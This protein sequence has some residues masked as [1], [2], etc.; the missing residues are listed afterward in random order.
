MKTYQT[1][2]NIAEIEKEIATRT[3]ER[4]QFLSKTKEKDLKLATNPKLINS[5]IEELC[6]QVAVY[7]PKATS[8]IYL[9]RRVSSFFSNRSR[10][11][12]VYRLKF[13]GNVI[14]EE[15][16]ANG[17]E[18]KFYVD[19]FSESPFLELDRVSLMVTVELPDQTTIIRASD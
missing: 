13:I 8:C 2:R 17:L 19:A 9:Q 10:P 14:C 12:W 4:R 11:S 7:G 15:L 5:A 6:D 3:A 16:R 1:P 18:A